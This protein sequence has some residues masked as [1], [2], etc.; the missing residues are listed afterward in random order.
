MGWLIEHE[1]MHDV[2]ADTIAQ[3]AMHFGIAFPSA[4]YRLERAGV[5]DKARKEELV[6]ALAAQ[7]RSFAKRFESSR[8]IDALER[9]ADGSAYPRV[10]QITDRYASDALKVNLIDQE[11]YE[12]IMGTRDRLDAWLA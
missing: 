8:H 12:E 2:D 5:I 9:I 6:H 11:E 1:H 3:M 10:P 4:C 7:G